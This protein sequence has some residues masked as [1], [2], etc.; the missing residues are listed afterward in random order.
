MTRVT[1]KNKHDALIAYAVK[2]VKINNTKLKKAVNTLEKKSRA[3]LKAENSLT[4]RLLRKPLK[5]IIMHVLE[6]GENVKSCKIDVAKAYQD[7]L[8]LKNILKQAA[9][10][11][12]TLRE[13]PDE[14]NV[15]SPAEVITYVNSSN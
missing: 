7:V 5:P 9:L 2:L 12:K 10:V 4:V 14:H 3:L 6:H 13:Q 1:V 15:I 8:D 11:E